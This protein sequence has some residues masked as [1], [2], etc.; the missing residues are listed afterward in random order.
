MLTQLTARQRLTLV[1]VLC[2]TSQVAAVAG[3]ALG[4]PTGWALGVGLTSGL[5]GMAVLVFNAL[6]L[7]RF[8]AEF[9]GHSERLA[10]GNL[11]QDI[12]LE[13]AGADVMKMMNG[14]QHLQTSLRQAL[15]SM[16]GGADGV[17]LAA[18]EI[19]QG[20]ADLSTRTEQTATNLQQAASSMTQLTS[21]VNQTAESARTANQLASSASEVA[22]RGGSVVAQVVS[23]MDEINTSS[24]KIADIIGTIDGIAFQTN[25]LALN[26]AVEAA[27]AGEQG[28]GFAVVASEVR[29]LAQRSAEAA[30]EIKSLIGASVEKVDSGSR[31]VQDA[32]NTMTEIVASV[33]RVSDIIGEISA[34][35]AE[36]SAGI[37]QVN[38]AVAVLDQMT[39]Q[40]AALVEES[41]AAAESLKDQS[42]Q[43][44]GAVASFQLG[45][46]ATGTAPTVL[47]GSAIHRA[48]T[49]SAAA[50]R[51][52][53]AKLSKPGSKPAAKPAQRPAAPSAAAPASTAPSRPAATTAAPAATAGGGNDDWE[54]F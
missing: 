9:S 24:K 29:S 46:S 4:A 26:A 16:R 49:T 10:Q 33:Q 22:A 38:Q 31:L 27:R 19:A 51:R 54:T 3:L 21:T 43:L 12:Q 2:G 25:I 14:L 5:A 37:S 1:L 28:R 18:Q 17:S 45:A 48:H 13:D 8:L 15:G 47:A 41:A 44:A 32:G 50:A 6:L 53:L 20:N 40:N 23:T 7:Q 39:Q 42:R 34:A 30:R 35:A 52:P 36:Q 11:S